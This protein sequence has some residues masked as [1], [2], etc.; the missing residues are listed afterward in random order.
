MCEGYA[1]STLDTFKRK[2]ILA[3]YRNF[4]LFLVCKEKE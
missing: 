2:H 1:I 3:D 4:I